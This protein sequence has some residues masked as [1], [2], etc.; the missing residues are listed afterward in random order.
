MIISVYKEGE[1]QMG[2]RSCGGVEIRIGLDRSLEPY[3]V[4]EN[5]KDE[6]INMIIDAEWAMFDEVD[7]MGGRAGCQDDGRTFYIMRYSNHCCLSEETLR[8]YYND[9][10]EAASDGRN[11]ITEKYAYMM[12][13]TDPDYFEKELKEKLPKITGK[14]Q[15]LIDEIVEITVNSELRFA[16][17]YPYFS[18]GSRP[19]ENDDAGNTSVRT[20]AAGEYKTYSEATLESYLEDLNR[21]LASGTEPSYAV[22]DRM[23]KFY[24]YSGIDDAE[25]QISSRAENQT[26]N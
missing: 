2:C 23:V 15:K 20:Y 7:N 4:N 13:L 18:R 16:E 10:A 8:S 26:E 12:E 22:H 24:G 21:M 19:T 3:K 25:E 14:K 11:L 9:I 6:I 17:K 5:A 1:K